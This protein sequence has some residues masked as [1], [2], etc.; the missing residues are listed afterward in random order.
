MYVACGYRACQGDCEGKEY[1]AIWQVRDSAFKEKQKC[2]L[3]ISH[4]QMFALELE[5]K[6]TSVSLL[7]CFN[8]PKIQHLKIKIL[9]PPVF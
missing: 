7:K 4:S 9:Q 1:A 3:G 6:Q 5:T 2:S 8:M